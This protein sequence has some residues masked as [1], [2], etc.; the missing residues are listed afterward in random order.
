MK[1]QDEVEELKRA[2]SKEPIWDI[3]DTEGFEDYAKELEE[4]QNHKETQWHSEQEKIVSLKA[5]EMG[6]SP[7]TYKTIATLETK[8]TEV[9]EKAKKLLLHYFTLLGIP[10]SPDN[11]AEIKGVVDCII[12][13][14]VFYN[15]AE[16]LKNPL[17]AKQRIQ[18]N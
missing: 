3:A 16:I 13:A 6:V 2:W 14:A 10:P 17:C 7:E 18:S 12:S 4:F 9:T 15:Q 8:A 1:T 5:K 11:N